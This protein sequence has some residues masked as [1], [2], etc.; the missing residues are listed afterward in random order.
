MSKNT[1]YNKQCEICQKVMK[2][3]KLPFYHCFKDDKDYCKDHK[4]KENYLL[5]QDEENKCLL[6]PDDEFNHF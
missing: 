6:Y 1:C 5:I 4:P 2:E 3:T